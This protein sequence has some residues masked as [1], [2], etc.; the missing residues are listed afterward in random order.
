M[1]LILGPFMV[2]GTSVVALLAG[3]FLWLRFGLELLPSDLNVDIAV[4]M[5]HARAKR[6][7]KCECVS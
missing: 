5:R 1:R 6:T 7:C 2:W 4:Q 3:S